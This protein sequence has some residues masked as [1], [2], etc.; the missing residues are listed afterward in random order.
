MVWLG[1]A[2]ASALWL[3]AFQF[4]VCNFHPCKLW[5]LCEYSAV[6]W[7]TNDQLFCLNHSVKQRERNPDL[8][9]AKKFPRFVMDSAITIKNYTILYVSELIIIRNWERKRDELRQPRRT[10]IFYRDISMCAHNKSAGQQI[11]SRSEERKGNEIHN[12]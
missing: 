4:F 10:H 8:K 3:I 2:Y 5:N 11:I 7:C 12:L 1:R 6:W 9:Q